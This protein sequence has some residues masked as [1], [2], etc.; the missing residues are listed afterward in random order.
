MS[1]ICENLMKKYRICLFENTRE[2]V[3][4]YYECRDIIKK[5]RDTC[6]LKQT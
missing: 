4:Q 1:E 2:G 6:Q 3:W 5:F